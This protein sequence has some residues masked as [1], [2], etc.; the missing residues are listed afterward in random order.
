MKYILSASI[1]AADCTILGEQIKAAADAGAQYIHV[2]VMDGWFVPSMSFGI[3]MVKSLRKAT[4]KVFDVHLMVQ[5]PE[6]Y[7]NEFAECG[8]N[9]ITVHAEA[10][11]HLDRCLDEIHGV[12]CKA[13]VALNPATPLCMLDH[14]LSKTDMVLIMTVNPGFGGAKYVDEM[15]EKISALRER[16]NQKG[17]PIDIQVDGGIHM[18]TLRTVLD[19][20]ANV[21]VAGSAIYGEGGNVKENVQRFLDVMREYEK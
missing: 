17:Y 19:A 18:G 8:A 21:I 10:C 5:E 15:T 11:M 12:G 20:G 4:D 2:D 14:I 6:R 16:I 13:G 1:L 7:I 9:I 3:P